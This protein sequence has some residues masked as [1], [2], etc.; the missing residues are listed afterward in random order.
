MKQNWPKRTKFIVGKKN[1][2]YEP[3]VKL[4]KVLLPPLQIKLGLMKQFVKALDK[5]GDCF[6]YL[7]V[8]CPAITKEKLKASVIDGPQIRRLVN[9]PAFMSSMQSA[10]LG[11]WNV[12][13]VKVTKFLGNTKTEYYKLLVSNLL[14]VLRMLGCNGSVK[15]HLLHIHVDYFPDNFGAVRQ[16]RRERFHQDIKTM[17]KRN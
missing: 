1:I 12:F 11:E 9:N 6:K 16:E 14:Q 10:E 8:K 2:E 15:V 3:L 7:C 13:P 5:D 4:E 17:Q